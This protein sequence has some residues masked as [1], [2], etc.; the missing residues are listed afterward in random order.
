MT[1]PDEGCDARHCV[2][3]V[4]ALLLAVVAFGVAIKGPTWPIFSEE[5]KKKKTAV[6]N[7]CSRG[8]CITNVGMCWDVLVPSEGLAKS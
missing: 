1:V 4:E 8:F 2:R 6:K 3:V 5:E 7:A